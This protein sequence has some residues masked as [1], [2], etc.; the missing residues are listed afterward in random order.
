MRFKEIIKKDVRLTVICFFAFMVIIVFLGSQLKKNIYVVTNNPKIEFQIKDS[1]ENDKEIFEDLIDLCCWM[2]DCQEKIDAVYS[3]DSI[4]KRFSHNYWLS[5]KEYFYNENNK[6]EYKLETFALENAKKLIEKSNVK[7]KD[8][9]IDILYET[10]LLHIAIASEKYKSENTNDLISYLGSFAGSSNE[11]DTFKI[12]I[13][14]ELD[15]E[16]ICEA[17]SEYIKSFY[18][19]GNITCERKD[20]IC[21]LISDIG[22]TKRFS[23]EIS[24]LEKYFEENEVK[25]NAENDNKTNIH[26]ISSYKRWVGVNGTIR[27]R[28]TEICTDKCGNG[29]DSCISRMLADDNSCTFEYGFSQGNDNGWIGCYKCGDIDSEYWFEWYREKLGLD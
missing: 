21:A 2:Y 1:Y 11:A 19:S 16:K 10:D 5:N 29:C 20:K 12:Q 23:E 8:E 27:Y 22:Q 26:K 4:S 18:S 17:I 14:Y 28:C 25:E 24:N 13:F 6:I 7:Y 15:N 9:I 3:Y